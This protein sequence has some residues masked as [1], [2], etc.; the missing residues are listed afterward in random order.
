MFRL[1][2]V[3]LAVAVACPIAAQ[4]I[5]APSLPH[6]LVE[7]WAKLPAGMNFGECTGVSCDRDDNVWIFNRGAHAVVQLDRNGNFLRSWTNVPVKSA[8]GLRIDSSGDVWGIDVAAHMVLKFS[9][10]GRVKMVLG[11]Q[12]GNPSADNNDPYA[13]NRPTSVAFD[14][15][16][17]FYVSDGYGNTRV[18]KYSKDGEY[19]KQWGVAGKGDGEFNLVH[20]VVLD[21]AGRVYVADRANDRVQV[22]DQEGRF[23]NKWSGVGQPWGLAYSKKENAIYLC[24]GKNNRVL[25]LNTDGQVLGQLGGFGKAPGKLDFAHHIA[26]DS[27]GAI[28][29]AE[30]KNWR[31]QKW[32]LE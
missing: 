3:A 30:V 21:Q 8:H 32:A 22:F 29:V 2:I 31:V 7:G 28:Y 17:N 1:T 23:L 13:F 6:K 11:G 15:K 19:L 10:D 9:V 16:G 14:E 20:D 27:R 24:D 5:N 4:P 18:A 25:K 26:V 12:G